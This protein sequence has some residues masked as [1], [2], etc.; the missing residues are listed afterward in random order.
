ME[1]R[2]Q[3]KRTSALKLY[4]EAGELSII[5]AFSSPMYLVSARCDEEELAVV[6]VFAVDP[7]R[8]SFADH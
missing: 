8:Q 7:I 6:I 2:Q 1:S 3:L 5:A 4:S